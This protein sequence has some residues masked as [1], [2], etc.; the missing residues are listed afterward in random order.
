MF[1]CLFSVK[2][3]AGSL[4]GSWGQS[5]REEMWEVWGESICFEKSS[6]KVIK[7]T[8]ECNSRIA[9]QSGLTAEVCGRKFQAKSISTATSLPPAAL[10]PFVTDMRKEEGSNNKQGFPRVKRMQRRITLTGDGKP[11]EYRGKSI[12]S[13]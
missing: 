7:K 10:S 1:V 13:R 11:G 4:A 6:Q 5:E 3:K 2:K 8:N 12:R 9:T